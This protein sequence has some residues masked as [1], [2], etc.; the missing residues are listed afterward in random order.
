MSKTTTSSSSDLWFWVRHIF[1]VFL[2]GVLYILVQPRLFPILEKVHKYLQENDLIS[3]SGWLVF[4]IMLYLI[5]W[6]VLHRKIYLPRSVALWFI[7]LLA[8]YLY[9]RLNSCYDFWKISFFGWEMPLVVWTDLLLLPIAFCLLQAC[10]KKDISVAEQEVAPEQGV[11]PIQN[12]VAI[13]RECDDWLGFSAT[14]KVLFEDLCLLDLRRE[15]LTMGIIAEWGKGKSSFINLLMNEVKKHGDIII[16][17][18]P[19]GSKSAANIQEDFFDA[20][21]TE[22]S[23]CYAGFGFLLGR[24]TKHLGLLG[25]YEWTRPLESLLMLLLP[26]KDVE[27]I[28]EAIS[29]L[30]KRIYVV[31]DDL[32]R[33]TG[34]EIIEVLKL[35]DRN[36]SF[37]NVVF[38]MAYD[39][40]YVNNVLRKHLDHGLDHSF[41]DKYVTW[42]VTLPEVDSGVLK[43]KMRGYLENNLLGLPEEEKQRVLEGWSYVDEIIAEN[44]ASVRHL[45]RYVNLTLHRYR[46]VYSKVDPADFFLLSLLQ[47]RHLTIY[48]NLARHID[49]VELHDIIHSSTRFVDEEIQDILGELPSDA[50]LLI[51]SMFLEDPV[52][53]EE[54]SNLP[55]DIE[56][57]LIR[58]REAFPYY[59]RYMQDNVAEE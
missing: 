37:N 28:N 35:V 56:K 12:D 9:Y 54:I 25:Q 50:L 13:K 7:L 34:E 58:S 52:G 11:Q 21:A 30:G 17:F 44:L 23:K 57:R 8:I 19:R 16:R 24:Y 6:I 2:V 10:K 5:C 22:L 47:Y 27:A 3:W 20:F 59:F 43:E 36:A 18:N 1:A 40:E 53:R 38:V 45:K 39:K 46:G 55:P 29:T 49:I 14:V 42:E 48:N 51:R 31:I 33:L 4:L 32:D 15:S 26:D 41:I